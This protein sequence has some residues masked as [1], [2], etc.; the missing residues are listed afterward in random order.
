[1]VKIYIDPRP[2][3]NAPQKM[4]YV[5]SN[6][7]FPEKKETPKSADIQAGKTVW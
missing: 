6:M 4:I 2:K 3:C 1:V 7:G 5:I